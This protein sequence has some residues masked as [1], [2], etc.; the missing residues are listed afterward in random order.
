L[1]LLGYLPSPFTHFSFFLFLFARHFAWQKEKYQK[2]IRKKRM[3]KGDKGDQLS[4]FDKKF[5]VIYILNTSGRSVR[6]GDKRLDFG[7]V[8]C[9]NKTVSLTSLPLKIKNHIFVSKT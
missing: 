1:S 7:Q 8:F 2:K 9:L 4:T 5:Q 6:G 3:S